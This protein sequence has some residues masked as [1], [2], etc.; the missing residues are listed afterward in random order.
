MNRFPPFYF[1][2]NKQGIQLYIH[3]GDLESKINIQNDVN[4]YEYLNIW[5]VLCID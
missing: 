3:A 4:V 2:K 1:G 5:N